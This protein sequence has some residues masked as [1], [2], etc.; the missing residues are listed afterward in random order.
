MKKPLLA[1]LLIAPLLGVSFTSSANDRWWEVRL[2][3]SGQVLTTEINTGLSTPSITQIQ[4]ACLSLQPIT[5]N[6][7]DYLFSRVTA[8]SSS[9]VRCHYLAANPDVVPQTIQYAVT[10]REIDEPTPQPPNPC[11]EGLSDLCCQF[12]AEDSCSALG[13]VHDFYWWPPASIGGER[14]DFTCRADV[15]D[16]TPPDNPDPDPNLPPGDDDPDPTEPPGDGDPNPDPDPEPDPDYDYTPP[17]P[18]QGAIVN[19]GGGAGSGGVTVDIDF[20]TSALEGWLQILA[21]KPGFNDSG[22]ITAMQLLRDGNRDD[23]LAI[24]D[25]LRTS[26]AHL[27]NIVA[28]TG[29]TADNADRMRIQLDGIADLLANIGDSLGSG[30]GGGDGGGDGGGTN[31]GDFP[32]G[33][34]SYP[35]RALDPDDPTSIIDF[36]H[37]RRIGEDYADRVE[38]PD[39]FDLD[40]FELDR[41]D[42]SDTMGDFQPFLPS[43]DC[44]GRRSYDI[45]GLSLTLDWS[46]MCDI[47]RWIGY[48]VMV[49]AWFATPFII[50]GA[51]KK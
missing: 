16:P 44:I 47:F 31:E 35:V 19:I 42:I 26:N 45:N 50:F 46:P 13:G 14:C 23:A 21:D 37:F 30:V 29:T 8:S 11:N 41:F 34:W 48:L 1:L 32:D 6:N 36:D 24:I 25:E 15:D 40:S 20:D 4:S 22:I 12:I 5:Y 9:T 18:G 7:H 49:S 38:L 28:Y 2:T 39:G 3:Y 27:D 33:D 43:A 10:F 51:S 17:S